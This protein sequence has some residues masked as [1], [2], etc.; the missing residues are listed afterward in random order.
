M[1]AATRQNLT[2]LTLAPLLSGYRWQQWLSCL[3]SPRFSQELS[4]WFLFSSSLSPAFL[5][6][7]FS[8][9]IFPRY[10]WS[11]NTENTFIFHL[12]NDFSVSST[13]TKLRVGCS[14]LPLCMWAGGSRTPASLC[15]HR[16]VLTSPCCVKSVRCS[17]SLFYFRIIFS[18]FCINQKRVTFCSGLP[19][20][21]NLT[22]CLGR[23]SWEC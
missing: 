14:W 9:L 20:A 21:H 17:T 11:Y 13:L 6:L 2:F 23:L 12:K 8:F 18:L 5:P 1:V 10:C 4:T 15:H 16:V 7:L 3:R 19:T 22:L